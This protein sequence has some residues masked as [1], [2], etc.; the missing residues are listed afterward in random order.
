MKKINLILILL[1]SFLSLYNCDRK[2]DPAVLPQQDVLTGVYSLREFSPGFGPF[3][4]YNPNDVIWQFMPDK[5][6]VVKINTTLL[7]NS[8]LP[9]VAST[10]ATYTLVND[11]K[12]TINEITYQISFTENKL[13]LNA[14]ASADGK[15][16]TFDKIEI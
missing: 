5:S 15:L 16:I 10:T 12:V 6:L 2:N 9:F 11:E 8:Q 13:I 4:T 3:E 14:D 1:V 7:A